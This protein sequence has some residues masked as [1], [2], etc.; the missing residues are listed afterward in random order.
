[1]RYV[2]DR[3][4]IQ[5]GIGYLLGC[6]LL[7]A[8]SL[9]LAS[10]DT[11]ADNCPGP[12]VLSAYAQETITVS[13]TSIG[14]T[15]ALIT[16]GAGDAQLASVSIETNAIRFFGNGS[17]PTASVGHP[18]AA[19]STITVCGQANIKNFRMIRQSADATATVSYYR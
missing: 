2:K 17:T 18:V 11:Q 19:G 10:V 7:M 8:A 14:F 6:A 9:H 12:A 3:P 5:L 16:Q 13:T 15:S 1:M 4:L